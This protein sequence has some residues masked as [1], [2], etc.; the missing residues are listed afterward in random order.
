MGAL[1][2]WLSLS[3]LCV[4]SAV[5]VFTGRKAPTTC[6]IRA[7]NSLFIALPLLQSAG[8]E[9]KT[10]MAYKTPVERLKSHCGK[11]IQARSVQS[12]YDT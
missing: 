3:T 9:I 11:S 1:E 8:R 10:V 2:A 12:H 6:D 5:N 7:T 4:A